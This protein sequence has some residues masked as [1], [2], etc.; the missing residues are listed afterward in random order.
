MSNNLVICVRSMNV[1]GGKE[2]A[3]ARIANALSIHYNV[4]ILAMNGEVASFYPL[5]PQVQQ[6]ALH[7]LSFLGKPKS[8][9]TVFQF[10]AG[11]KELAEFI[12]EKRP[13]LIIGNDFLLN[14]QLVLAKWY[15]RAFHMPIIGWEHI[16]LQD[17]V[18]QSR[19]M[20]IWL[21]NLFYKKLTALVV[22]TPSDEQYC[23]IRGI[24]PYLI[25]YPQ[26][27]TFTD[28]IDYE[29]KKVLTIAR[30]SHQKG[31]DLYCQLISLLKKHIGEWKFTLVGKEDDI[32][33]SDLEGFIRKY[34]IEAYVE[35]KSPQEDVISFYRQ[36][37][38]Y[39]LTS[40]Y[41]GLP[42]TLIEAQTCGLPCVSF[43]CKTGP[44][45]IIRHGT[46]GFIV[47]PFNLNEMANKLQQLMN[48]LSLR[49]TMGQES[50][51]VAQ[52]Y[53]EHHI[54]ERWHTLI[55]KTIKKQEK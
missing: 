55:T 54:M 11:I 26:S 41:E 3:V 18:I 44:S 42:I 20:L 47:P 23:N 25:P 53:N 2:R 21:R 49:K 28:E 27:F 22:V 46:S 30:F 35:V 40:R 12:N 17:P 36:A 50:K 9:K 24:K 45:D 19:R 38:I 32:S 37:S 29:Q 51:K 31:L 14:I 7:T 13:A 33:L 16:T 34:E 10:L 52:R 43:D 1:V 39:L 6:H 5:H 48:S 4:S 15:R 8:V